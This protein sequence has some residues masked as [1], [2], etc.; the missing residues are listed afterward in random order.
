MQVSVYRISRFSEPS[1]ATSSWVRLGPVSAR[2]VTGP[3]LNLAMLSRYPCS[4]ACQAVLTRVTATWNLMSLGPSPLPPL[5][6]CVVVADDA[7][8]DTCSKARYADHHPGDLHGMCTE[9][10]ERPGARHAGEECSN[11][12]L[13]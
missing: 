2:C 5:G 4:S 3:P 8:R 9:K 6:P 10:G 7:E 1:P 13:Q 11:R 12:G